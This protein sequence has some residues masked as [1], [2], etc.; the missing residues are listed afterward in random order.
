MKVNG[1]VLLLSMNGN[2]TKFEYSTQRIKNHKQRFSLY[3]QMLS[4]T[5]AQFS[6]NYPDLSQYFSTEPD[7]FL[8]SYCCLPTTATIDG[9]IDLTAIQYDRLDR[10]LFSIASDRGDCIW[11]TGFKIGKEE[12]HSQFIRLD[13]LG[14]GGIMYV[15]ETLD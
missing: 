8:I 11:K 3:K 1:H 7:P 6:N 5:K 15:K 2:K 14:V 4:Q 13:K 10:E 12:F 9:N